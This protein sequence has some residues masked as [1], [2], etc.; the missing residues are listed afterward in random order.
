MGDS[1]NP[2]ELTG[3]DV[4]MLLNSTPQQEVINRNR[5]DR[6]SAQSGGSCRRGRKWDLVRLI[7]WLVKLKHTTKKKK[8]S[9]EDQKESARRISAEKSL[10]GREIG[11][12]PK[13]KDPDRRA[14]CEFNLKLYCETYYP[15]LF[16]LPWSPD[17]IKVI[18]KIENATLKGGLF[19]MALP[20]GTG[21]STLVEI[22]GCWAISYGHRQF[23]GMFGPDEQHAVDML[24][25]IKS[26]F[27]HNDLLNEDFPEICHP[28]RAIEGNSQR[29]SGQLCQ[30]KRTEISWKTKEIIF[31]TVEGSKS[32]GSIIKTGGITGSI[33]GMKHKLVNGQAIRP[34]FVVVDDPQTDES[35]RSPSQ[36]EQRLSVVN[37]SILNLAGPGKKIAGF[38]PCTVIAEGDMADEILNQDKHPDWQG[39]RTSML[40]NFDP[41][42]KECTYNMK[43]WDEYDKIR[44]ESLRRGKG[45]TEATEFYRENR[46]QMDKGTDVSWPEN[47]NQDEISGLQHA[48]NLY[49]RNEEAFFSEGQNMPKKK[50]MGDT[51]LMKADEIAAKV[52]NYERRTIPETCNTLTAFVD[53]QKKLLYYTVVA[54][55][56]NGSGYI[57]DYGSYPDQQRSY[58]T[59]RDAKKTYLTAKVEGGFEAKLYKALK[60]LTEDLCGRAWIR[61][62]QL[63]MTMNVMMIDANW[64]DSTATVY[65][66]CRTS[67]YRNQLKPCHG[68]YYG[69]STI[70][71]NER[72]RKKGDRVGHNWFIPNPKGKRVIRYVLYDTN[73]W[74]LYMHQ[75]FQVG[76][77]G[78]GCL[79]LFGTDAKRHKAFGEQ[80]SSEYTVLTEGRGRKVLEFKLDPKN[81]DNHWLDCVVGCCVGACISGVII[82]GIDYRPPK[83]VHKKRKMSEIIEQRRNQRPLN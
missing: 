35:A 5:L 4:L 48:M 21:K 74:K 46:E 32:S 36:N 13:V 12:P 19:A 17:H 52:N 75:R 44:A 22:A 58:F 61:D 69:A 39:F 28:I 3:A 68:K 7:A 73:A 20:R 6:Y 56:D 83:K 70:P 67:D 31:P 27:E 25:S 40:N 2:N 80:I 71:M 53:V 82:K 42:D 18:D 45:I 26:E 65:Q 81:P 14:S 79:S 43:M 77:G 34:D 76:L 41:D 62:D 9:Y 72:T 51:D 54:W 16:N 57:I 63:E 23:I 50:E 37:G 29:T 1:I 66:F 15:V 60:N 8:Y 11:A 10:S 49:Y 59:L 33:R 55:D 30:G 64:H 47:F 24:S 38:M 78:E